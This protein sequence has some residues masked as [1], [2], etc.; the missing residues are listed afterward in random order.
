MD[1]ISAATTV[2]AAVEA[3][4]VVL[5]YAKGVADSG[6]ERRRLESEV[7][8]LAILMQMLQPLV[9]AAKQRND[10]KPPGTKSLG[11]SG[12]LLEQ[13]NDVLDDLKSRYCLTR[14]SRKGTKF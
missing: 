2:I 14:N 13:A 12:G 4:I 5:K 3:G 7:K 11:D 8:S 6:K 10:G 1:G 9:D